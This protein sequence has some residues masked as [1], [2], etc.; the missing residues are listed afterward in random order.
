MAR[1]ARILITAAVAAVGISLAPELAP[2][3]DAASCVKIYEIYYDSPGSDTGSNSSLNAEWIQLR[4]TCSVDR[5]LTGWRIRDASNHWYTFG[6]YTLRAGTK[7]KIHTGS[8]SNSRTDRY[9]GRGW[10]IWNNTGGD[11]GFLYNSAGSTVDTCAFSGGSP[12]Y[13]YC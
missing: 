4:S 11:K 2:P 1:G 12:G 5:S 10:Y 6:T 13:V 7:V 9:Q 3:T 8:G